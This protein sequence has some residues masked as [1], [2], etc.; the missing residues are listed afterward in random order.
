MQGPNT[1]A[2]DRAGS[3]AASR[4]GG[5]RSVPTLGRYGALALLL[6]ASLGA[7]PAGALTLAVTGGGLTEGPSVACLT[8]A[9]QCEPEA[10]F[11]F[12]TDADVSGSIEIVGNALSVSVQIGSARFE[13]LAPSGLAGDVEGLDFTGLEYGGGATVSVTDLPGYLSAIAYAA[14][15]GTVDGTYSTEDAF[16]TPVDAASVFGV[17]TT[18]TNVNCLVVSGTGQCSLQFGRSDFTLGL[19]GD[20]HDSIHFL[21]LSVTLIPEPSTALL[22]ACAAGALLAVP[23]RRA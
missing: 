19:G 5:G 17:D 15:S 20:D 12:V 9:T 22:L 2:G 1:R 4:S 23:R 6:L 10:D 11:G 7:A 16:S 3:R 18:L 13:A 8:S 21:N 14:G